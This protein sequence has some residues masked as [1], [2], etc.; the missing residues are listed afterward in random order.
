[1]GAVHGIEAATVAPENKHE[2]FTGAHPMPVRNMSR[3]PFD[4]E[5]VAERTFPFE[6]YTKEDYENEVN[7][8]YD[9]VVRLFADRPCLMQPRRKD[10]VVAGL[11]VRTAFT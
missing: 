6:V 11:R 10:A 1:M 4:L 2:Q 5:T 9:E 7:R 3:V 8:V